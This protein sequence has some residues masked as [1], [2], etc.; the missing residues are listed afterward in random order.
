MGLRLDEIF[1]DSDRYRAV[2]V[3]GDEAAF[4]L[5]DPTG[6]IETVKRRMA[7]DS[8]YPSSQVRALI[9]ERER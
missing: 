1:L 6:P 4:R 7:E 3:N 2:H 5:A 8:T 9:L